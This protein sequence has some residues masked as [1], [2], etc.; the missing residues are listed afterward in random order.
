MSD[1]DAISAIKSRIDLVSLIGR[2]LKLRKSGPRE[3]TACC[4]FHSERTPSFYVIPDKEIWHCFGC[5]ETGDAFAYLMK[6]EGL[7]FP[8]ALEQLAHEAGVELPKREHVD[9]RRN[10]RID[11]MRAVLAE[12]QEFFKAQVISE[13][14]AVCYLQGRGLTM[15]FIEQAGLGVAPDTWDMLSKHLQSVGFK[16]EEIV[17][18]GVGAVG[19]KGG[20]IDF[21]RNRVTIPIKDHLGKLVAF[22]GRILDDSK[23]KYLNTRETDLF[24]KGEVLFGLHE[25]KGHA[26]DGVLVV[27]GYFDVLTL[28]HLGIGY[29]VAPLGTA[30]TEA[31]LERL[32]RYTKRI[33]L[34]F[35]GDE[36]GH[37]AMEKSLQLALPKGFDVRLLE[38]PSGEDPDTWAMSVGQEAFRELV[39]RAPDWTSFKLSRA[40][41]DRDMRKAAERMDVLQELAPMLRYVP[42]EGRD[43]FFA[44]LAHQLQLPA[45]EV[46]KAAGVKTENQPASAPDQLPKSAQIGSKLAVPQKVDEAVKAL[47]MAWIDPATKQAIVDT[48]RSWWQHLAGAPLLEEILDYA[49]ITPEAEALVRECDARRIVGGAPRLERLLASLEGAYIESELR[50]LRQGM[51][52]PRTTPDLL[53]RYERAQLDLLARRSR[54]NHSRALTGA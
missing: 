53:P 42:Q 11:R 26:Q 21:L 13:E 46:A 10:D 39:R 51:E 47:V 18:A 32:A 33:T 44:T 30:L 49:D 17:A 12:A 9:T 6:A 52:D 5:N 36:A 25:A 7:T 27:E 14:D 34:C 1:R 3:W 43:A 20:I 24:H 23:P 31:H 50:A 35:D 37:R 4:P 19:Q 48:P 45:F 15:A 38:L 28:Q 2:N 8:E 40:I 54:L 22:G 41:K 29:A 16:G